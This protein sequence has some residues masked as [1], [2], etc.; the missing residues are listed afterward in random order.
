MSW[1]V[2]FFLDPAHGPFTAEHSR[3]LVVGRRGATGG[4]GTKELP[5]KM[6]C[7]TP[8]LPII[9][10]APKVHTKDLPTWRHLLVSTH[11]NLAIW[12]DYAF[13]T[14]ISRNKRLGIDSLLVNAS[15][16]V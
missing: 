7:P 15:E 3:V 13:D 2:A 5:A 8:R 1:V 14:M 6:M 11:N 9:P 12:P 16:G 4:A 10:A